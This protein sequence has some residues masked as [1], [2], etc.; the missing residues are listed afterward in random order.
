LASR[1]EGISRVDGGLLDAFGLS[2]HCSGNF[3]EEPA[4]RILIV[5]DEPTLG[6]QLKNTLEQNGYAID[7]TAISSALPRNTTR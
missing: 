3:L 5:E 2:P 1:V 6:K 4:M 7:L